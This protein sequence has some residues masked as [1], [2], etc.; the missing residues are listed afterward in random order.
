MSL[1]VSIRLLL[2]LTVLVLV[3]VPEVADDGVDMKRGEEED[4]EAL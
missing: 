2:L 1:F 3:L 4:R